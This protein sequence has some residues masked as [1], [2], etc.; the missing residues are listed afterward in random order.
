M[1]DTPTAIDPN[2]PGT[3]H[4]SVS[5]FL[6]E[7]PVAT[8]EAEVVTPEPRVTLV[9]PETLQSFIL[10][11]HKIAEADYSPWLISVIARIEAYCRNM[12]YAVPVTPAVGTSQ[13]RI[14]SSMISEVLNQATGNCTLGMDVISFMVKTNPFPFTPACRNRFLENLHIGKNAQLAYQHLLTVLSMTADPK[15][16]SMALR[17]IDLTQIIQYLPDERAKHN[18]LTYYAG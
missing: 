7:A 10:A 14:L 6:G 5:E 1:T 11:K 2:E 13:Q 3:A 4:Q 18:L 16:R 17:R 8:P 15:T 12:G 9:T